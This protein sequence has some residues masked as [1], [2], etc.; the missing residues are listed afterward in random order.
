MYVE[1]ALRDIPL[2]AIH[3]IYLKLERY[4]G[5]FMYMGPYLLACINK[6]RPIQNRLHF[7]DDVFKKMFQF[8]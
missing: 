4:I 5:G 2:T 7:P 8:R 3:I 6:L 1:M